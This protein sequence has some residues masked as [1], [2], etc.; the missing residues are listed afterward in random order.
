MLTFIELYILNEVA[1]EDFDEFVDV[2]KDIHSTKS[3]REFIGFTRE[4]F[5]L[6]QSD[7][8]KLKDILDKYA[9]NRNFIDGF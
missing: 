6:W 5:I 2:C 8:S 3:L 9:Q 7:P 1:I 4:E